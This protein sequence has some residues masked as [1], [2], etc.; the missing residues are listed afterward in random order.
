VALFFRGKDEN[1]AVA[2]A[3]DSVFGLGGSVFTADIARG[4]RVATGVLTMKNV[5]KEVVFKVKSLSF[6]PGLKG[7][8]ISGWEAALTLDR[9]DFDI[10]A[11][12][13][14]V[15]NNVDILINVEADPQ[16]PAPAKP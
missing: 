9:H 5:A 7:A 6:G 15:G 11:D 4:K 2:L 8:A 16:N 14:A 13:G 1:E 12:Q 10:T 3:N